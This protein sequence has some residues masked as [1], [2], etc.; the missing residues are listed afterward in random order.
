MPQELAERTTYM[1]H[2]EI[3]RILGMRDEWLRSAPELL[4]SHLWVQGTDARYHKI[5]RYFY[6]AYLGSSTR[7]E[8]CSTKRI[9][10]AN[11]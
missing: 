1:P 6:G 11:A 8:R 9:Y 2:T 4:A 10:S 3:R 5:I 7:T